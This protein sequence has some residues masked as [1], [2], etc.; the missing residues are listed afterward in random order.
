M[1]R[2]F[3]KTQFHRLRCSAGAI[4]EEL[5]KLKC[6]TLQIWCMCMPLGV[7]CALFIRS[8][9]S[10][11]MLRDSV[12][13]LQL[14]QQYMHTAYTTF[15]TVC[16]LEHIVI[17]T[18]T[19]IQASKQ[20]NQFR[21]HSQDMYNTYSISP[22]TTGG[23]TKGVLLQVALCQE[24]PVGCRSLTY[25]KTDADVALGLVHLCRQLYGL[26]FTPKH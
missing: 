14:H 11:V 15:L 20:A 23:K 10:F 25:L 8:F 16:L 9:L 21:F 3:L 4:D 6:V 17:N 24:T 2:V 13:K 26:P 18:H 19:C 5:M 22:C 12:T 1:L 7:W